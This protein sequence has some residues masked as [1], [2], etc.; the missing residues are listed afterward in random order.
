MMASPAAGSE[1]R[2]TAVVTGGGSGIGAACAR[3]LAS[4][5]HSVVLVGRRPQPLEQTRDAIA[6]DGG[7]AR[8]FPADVRD[9]DRVSELYDAIRGWT[10]R[11][12]VVINA[13]GGQF[14]MPAEE[15]TPNGWR[16]VVDTNLTGTFLV[17]QRLFPLLCHRG[18]SIVN[19][20]ANIWQRAAPGMAHSGAAR[21]GVVSLTRTLALEW[22]GRGIRVNALSP[23]LTDTAALRAEL[24]DL[25]GPARR[26]PLQRL[27]APEEVADAA[28]FIV[29][30]PYI[31]GE[32]LTIDGG[33]H[34][35]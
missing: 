1:G 26:V 19:V 5:G 24:G 27:A 2:P 16:A 29:S 34:L 28:M 3:R 30:S 9:A 21:A 31:T 4:T 22:A 7:T 10:D 18:G 8:V 32:V 25:S 35:R 20:V 12:D 14:R 13:A 23:G 6:G 15:L 17:C 11:V 33:S